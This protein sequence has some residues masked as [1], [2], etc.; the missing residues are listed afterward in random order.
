MTA[1]AKSPTDGPSSGPSDF[2]LPETALSRAFDR[3]IIFFGEISSWLW[4]VL[5]LLIVYQVVQ[6]Y[7]FSIGS[8]KLE[9]VQWHL[10]AIGF[11]L[12]LAFTE[13][14]QR[15]VRID[16]FAEHLS[17]PTRLWIELGG[18]LFLLLPF[19]LFMIW[20]AI[21]FVV[22]SWELNE[23]SAAPDGLPYRWALKSFIVTA[24]VLVLMAGISR[25]SRVIAALRA[26]GK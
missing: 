10:Y 15:H 12:G 11:L 6:R 23:I 25:L 13:V 20:Y 22:T 16:V 2:S 24:F 4:T 1:E 21:P 18:I 14:R 9:E 17:R 5:M 8:I 7:V 19:A 26:P 3:I